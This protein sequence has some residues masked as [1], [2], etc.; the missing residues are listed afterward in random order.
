L[1]STL[2][3]ESC[4]FRR[5]LRA[6]ICGV[7]AAKSDRGAILGQRPDVIISAGNTSTILGF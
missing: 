3:V 4:H 1:Y 2:V 5:L 6:L 7:F